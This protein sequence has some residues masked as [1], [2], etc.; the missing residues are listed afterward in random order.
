MLLLSDFSDI[1]ISKIL[2]YQNN[3]TFFKCSRL[4][5][6][7]NHLPVDNTSLSGFTGNRNYS[8]KKEVTGFYSYFLP[9]RSRLVLDA[10]CVPITSTSWMFT[11]LGLVATKKMSSATSFAFNGVISS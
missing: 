11:C 3:N 6:G 1:S 10:C 7:D 2:H 9:L 4:G 5:H 8:Q